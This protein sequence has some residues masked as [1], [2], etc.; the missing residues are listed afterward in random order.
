MTLNYSLLTGLLRATI[1]SQARIIPG[2]GMASYECRVTAWKVRC[3]WSP[4]APNGL[5]GRK[6]SNRS[7]SI[8]FQPCRW[9]PVSTSELLHAQQETLHCRRGGIDRMLPFFA[10]RRDKRWSDLE[11]KAVSDECWSASVVKASRLSICG[12]GLWWCLLVSRRLPSLH[13]ASYLP[14]FGYRVCDCHAVSVRIAQQRAHFWAGVH[15]LTDT[16]VLS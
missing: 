16:Q 8:T 15:L 13:L 7:R 11:K 3:P 2:P 10:S 5:T 4:S 14:V 9:S 6:G 1:S 12:S